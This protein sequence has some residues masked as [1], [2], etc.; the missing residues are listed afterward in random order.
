MDNVKTQ[1]QLLDDEYKAL[2]KL[3]TDLDEM[4]NRLC[5][6]DE[7]SAPWAAKQRIEIL[8]RQFEEAGSRAQH[9]EQYAMILHPQ[10][11]EDAIILLRLAAGVAADHRQDRYAAYQRDQLLPRMIAEV[12]A[13]FVSEAPANCD[14]ALGSDCQPWLDRSGTELVA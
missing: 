5:G 7:A 14:F 8:R 3:R 13:F 11:R 12:V 6:D 2:E 4:I 9:L 10:C 1:L